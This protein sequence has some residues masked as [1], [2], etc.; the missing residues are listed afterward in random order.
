M[1]ENDAKE[2]CEN[3]TKTP[4]RIIASYTD[5]CAT[6]IQGYNNKKYEFWVATTTDAIDQGFAVCKKKGYK[7]CK[8]VFSSCVLDTG[9]K[10][11]FTKSSLKNGMIF[12]AAYLLPIMKI[13]KTRDN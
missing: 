12:Q 1:A 3:K 6:G 4:C 13:L 8:V 9:T 7:N 2:K 5:T 11:Q 10:P